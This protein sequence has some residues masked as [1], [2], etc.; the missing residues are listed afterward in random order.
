MSDQTIETS[1]QGED[2]NLTPDPG[3]TMDP[4]KILEVIPE[5]VRKYLLGEVQEQPKELAQAMDSVAEKINMGVA[6]L[7]V[8]RLASM[9][10]NFAF[11]QALEESL[12][13]PERVKGM[14]GKQRMSD[15]RTI[16]KESNE[17]MEFVRKFTLQNKEMFSKKSQS[18]ELS[19]L[20][21]KRPGA[22][23]VVATRP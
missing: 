16:T 15:Y 18:D 21:L 7:V 2:E 23:E 5:P 14:D 10:R 1:P 20:N 11:L 12:F 19:R 4:N 13:D 17:F 3:V 9:S 6:F 22:W 8:Q